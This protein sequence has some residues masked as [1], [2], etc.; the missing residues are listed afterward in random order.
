MS[1]RMVGYVVQDDCVLKRKAVP[2]CTSKLSDEKILLTYC[3][4][5][6]QEGLPPRQ[7]EFI[8]LI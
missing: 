5:R 1:L 4:F 2:A 6:G 7:V 8:P 3:L